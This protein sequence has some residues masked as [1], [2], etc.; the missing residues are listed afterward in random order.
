MVQKYLKGFEGKK[1]FVHKRHG[2]VFAQARP[3]V[4]IDD[5]ANPP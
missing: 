3:S 4:L 5:E 1:I 2:A